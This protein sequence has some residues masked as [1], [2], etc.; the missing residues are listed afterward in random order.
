M[1]PLK[2]N[3]VDSFDEGESDFDSVVKDDGV[4]DVDDGPDGEQEQEA[5]IAELVEEVV[6]IEIR[7][8]AACL[9]RTPSEKARCPRRQSQA[10]RNA[11]C[12]KTG[13]S[14][15]RGQSAARQEGRG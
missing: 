2:M 14:E 4:R 7:C 8:P 1:V 9:S 10:G 5:P 6:V 3:A 13:G 11:S 12:S 15:A